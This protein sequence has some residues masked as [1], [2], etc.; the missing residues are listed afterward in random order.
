[1]HSFSVYFQLRAA[2]WQASLC[3][4]NIQQRQMKSKLT[5][6]CVVPMPHG[7]FYQM[8]FSVRSQ[9][10]NKRIC[11]VSEL[12][13]NPDTLTNDEKN[14]PFV[15]GIPE[16]CWGRRKNRVIGLFSWRTNSVFKFWRMCAFK[17]L[18]ETIFYCRFVFNFPSYQGKMRSS[19]CFA[20]FRFI[21]SYSLVLLHSRSGQSP[22]GSILN[23]IFEMLTFN[24]HA[25]FW[26]LS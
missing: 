5:G 16:N 4:G 6:P 1:M 13:I 3:L 11:A 21:N 24:P 25:I 15:L 10:T 14:D 20:V 23:P 2:I 18:S 19:C 8:D 22:V 9:K 12:C 7:A 26:W 17:M